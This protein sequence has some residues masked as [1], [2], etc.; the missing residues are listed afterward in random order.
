MPG[1]NHDGDSLGQFIT[2]RTA[3]A[4][5]V[6]RGIAFAPQ[7]KDGETTTSPFSR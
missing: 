6:L 4:G 1:G 5:E 2:I 7:N 3:Q